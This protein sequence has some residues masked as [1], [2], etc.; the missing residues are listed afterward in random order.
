[1]LRFEKIPY[2]QFC[3]DMVKIYGDLQEEFIEEKYNSIK[4]P[5]RATGW[6]A[7]YDFYAI[8]D[9]TICTDGLSTV[10]PTGVKFCTDDPTDV[11]LIFPRS[12]LGF[13]KGAYLENTVG[14]IDADYQ[15]A[16]NYGHIMIKMGCRLDSVHLVPGE[17]F[18]QGI[19]TKFLK[20]DDDNP[21]SWDR[22]GG[23][24]STTEKTKG[25]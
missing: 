3:E 10:I 14:V 24:G 22:D 18:C 11:L 23:F 9:E 8:M 17:A 12:G 21:V 13:K 15:F 2:K 5:R 7:G 6:S 4:L 16:K 20:T 19:I 1:M 25:I